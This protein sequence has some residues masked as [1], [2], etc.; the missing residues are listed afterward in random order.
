M[1]KSKRGQKSAK[2]Q[3]TRFET[4]RSGNSQILSVTQL[5]HV[6]SF[7]LRT[8]FHQ[9]RVMLQTTHNIC[10]TQVLYGNYFFARNLLGNKAQETSVS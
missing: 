9:K 2:L 10:I 6:L 3:T 8:N 1:A 4:I 7:V 5:L